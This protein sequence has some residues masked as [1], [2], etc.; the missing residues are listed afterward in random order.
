MKNTFALFCYLTLLLPMSPA[1]ATTEP[2]TLFYSDNDNDQVYK[3]DIPSMTIL[4]V[5]DTEASPYPIDL[6]GNNRIYVSTRD[7]SSVGIINICTFEEEIRLALNHQPRS[8]TYNA[9]KKRILVSGKNK[10]QTTLIKTRNSQIKLLVGSETYTQPNDFGG[11]NATGH[12]FWVSN[13]RFLQLDR[14]TKQLQLYKKNGALLDVLPMP[15]AMHH[16]I[17]NGSDFYAVLEGSPANGIRPGL[18]RFEITGKNLNQTGLVYLT[19]PLGNT[20]DPWLMGGHHASFHPDGDL[21]Y[22][23]SNEGNLYVINRNSMA[24]ITVTPAGKGAGHT[25]FAVEQNMALITNH[26]DTFVSVIDTN[27]HQNIANI[28]VSGPAP[29]GRKTQGHTVNVSPDGNYFYGS[30]SHDGNIFEINLNQLSL[31]RTLPIPSSYLLQGTFQWGERADS[32]GGQ[33]CV[34]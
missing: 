31:T 7:D 22:M 25:T 27:T 16:I 26:N 6:A 33:V 8:S 23:G 13:N 24:V 20:P 12:P 34:N 15:T 11:S 21:I 14:T 1:W 9:D 5:T 18:L 17:R 28:P 19:N 32:I 30:A 4:S 29:G 3:I 2:G 10:P